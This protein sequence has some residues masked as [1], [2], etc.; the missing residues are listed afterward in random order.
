MVNYLFSAVFYAKIA[1]LAGFATPA[2]FR[3]AY[4]HFHII[5]PASFGMG[6]PFAGLGMGG[7]KTILIP[8]HD[9]INTIFHE[10]GHTFGLLHPTNHAAPTA[11]GSDYADYTDIMAVD[12]GG[13]LGGAMVSMLGWATPAT[14]V[15]DA[16][17]LPT[18]GTCV[19]A[20][21]YYPYKG[22]TKSKGYNSFIRVMP[23]W[24]TNATIA[25]TPYYV[26]TRYLLLNSDLPLSPPSFATLIGWNKGFGTAVSTI[27]TLKMSPVT[28]VSKRATV[29][30]AFMLPGVVAYAAQGLTVAIDGILTV[31][32]VAYESFSLRARVR[33]CRI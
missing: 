29:P 14:P 10:M 6:C 28:V 26:S 23:T 8:N 15:I 16:T 31:K 12:A 32:Q 22:T 30:G 5:S 4:P 21:V 25:A 27:N 20:Y 19:D 24:S 1:K 7:S 17:Y 9:N 18:A 33:I 13:C 11:S 2:A 3:L